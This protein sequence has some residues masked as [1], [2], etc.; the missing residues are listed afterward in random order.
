VWLNITH[1][2]FSLLLVRNLIE[3][4][5]KNPYP[6]LVG[7]PSVS[8]FWFRGH[9]GYE[10]FFCSSKNAGSTKISFIVNQH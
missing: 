10:I 5:G 8:L 2:D 3:D 1:Q 6:R 4:A 7:R 9:K